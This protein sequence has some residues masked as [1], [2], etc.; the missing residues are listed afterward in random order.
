MASPRIAIIG[1]GPAGL[2]LALLLH[3]REVPF[4]IYERRPRPT[5]DALAQPSGVLDLHE[6]SGLAAIRACGLYDEFVPLTG[7]CAESM[8]IVNSDGEIL[9]A[10]EGDDHRP[11]ISRHALTKLL[12]SKLPPDA[13]RWEH[14][15]I[16]ATPN[17]DNTTDL[18]FGPAQGTITAD[19]LVGADGAWSR[20]R[21][22][23]TPT[24]PHYS[25]VHWI[26]MTIPQITAQYP[27][28]ADFVGLGTFSALADR[29]AVMSQRGTRDSLRV[30]LA[31][32]TPDVNFS[33][34]AGLAG[35]SPQ[36]AKH[37]LLTQDNLF[38]KWT[39][40]LRELI[41]RACEEDKA[42]KLDVMGMHMLPVDKLGWEH[43][44]GVTLVGDA[45]HLM[46]P[47]AGEGV[48]LAMWDALDLAAVVEKAYAGYKAGGG[49]QQAL[50]PLMKEFEKLMVERVEEKARE[51]WRNLELMMGDNAA[52]KFA[53][54]M[55]SYTPPE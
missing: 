17:A 19:L 22:L 52:E 6:E 4:T 43:K 38:A 27:H 46:T 51:T 11:E 14:K 36:A 23:L 34:T 15:L 20:I 1:A 31:I 3:L 32:H 45:A 21:P 12:L 44:A 33:T 9:Y 24:K 29:K 7:E 25:G 2:T 42:D 48:N 47:F 53:A 13:I 37:R 8:R 54:L 41:E 10:D 55:N 49:F 16:R 50:E 40:P 30:Y 28:L 35:L 5:E 18:D 26:T 39:G